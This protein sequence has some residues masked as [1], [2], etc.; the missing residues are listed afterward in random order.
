M[1]NDGHLGDFVTVG[2]KTVIGTNS[3]IG[4][5]SKIGTECNIGS[6][7]IVS[8]HS[9]IGNKINIGKNAHIGRYNDIFANIAESAVVHEFITIPS[10]MIVEKSDIILLLPSSGHLYF[11][12]EKYYKENDKE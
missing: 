8:D 4:S 6:D 7:S 5:N 12:S 3:K 9:E 11:Q 1:I 2:P 10:G